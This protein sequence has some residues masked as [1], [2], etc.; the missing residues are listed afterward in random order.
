M[1]RW[2]TRSERLTED[3]I[4][5]I[6]RASYNSYSAYW[7]RHLDPE[8]CSLA[9]FSSAMRGELSSSDIINAILESIPAATLEQPF[10]DVKGLACSGCGCA[11][12]DRPPFIKDYS[13]EE[14]VHEHR[15]EDYDFGDRVRLKG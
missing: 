14:G 6:K 7:R 3:I 4:S 9:Q 2:Q 8:V 13:P 1:G 15:Y 12:E 11:F 5:A 10:R